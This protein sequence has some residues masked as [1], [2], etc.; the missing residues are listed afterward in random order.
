MIYIIVFI[1]TAGAIYLVASNL[2][3]K[4]TPFFNKTRPAANIFNSK[5][6]RSLSSGAS[7]PFSKTAYFRLLQSQADFIG[8]RFGAAELLLIKE[9]ALITGGILGANLF[10]PV[11]ALAGAGIGFFLPDI[12][13]AKKISARKE[14]IIKYFPETV[15]LMDLCIG[16]GLD[17]L[18]SI[19]WISQK[20]YQNP[21]IAQLSVV[22]EEIQ[23]GK[24]RSD[25]LRAMAKRLNLSDINSFVRTIIQ[26]ERMGAS[27]EE[28]L[29]NIS[30]DTRASR[31]QRGERYA[32]KASLKILIPLLFFILPV[33]MIVVAGPII[34]KFTQ[35]GLIP[36]GMGP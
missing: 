21:F 26:A 11:Y 33:I 8:M 24:N 1:L 9:L 32:I 5:I 30:E 6:V 10:S 17:F 34:I 13:L 12:I 7:R 2:S 23:A 25:A 27:V 36:T 4:G 14:E 35:G 3:S 20:S 28:A 29:R 31:F 22:L 19:R 16:A 18:S 15:D